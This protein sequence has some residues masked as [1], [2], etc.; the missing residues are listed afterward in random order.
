MPHVEINNI[1]CISPLHR[2]SKGLKGVKGECNQAS[3]CVIDG[4][5][6]ESCL[7]FKLQEA[8]IPG[9]KSVRERNREC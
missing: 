7:D 4:S 3:Y 1:L 5:A 8:R 9:I 6:Q 2:D